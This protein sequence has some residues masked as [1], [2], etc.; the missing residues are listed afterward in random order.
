VQIQ[1]AG[2]DEALRT[3]RTGRDGLSPEEADRRLKE[4]GPNEVEQIVGA[5]LLRRFGAEFV[6]LFALI[7]WSAAA[8]AFTA[9]AL[10]PGQGMRRLGWAIVGVIVVNAVASFWQV[11]RAERTIESLRR[12]LPARDGRTRGLRCR[13]V[14]PGAGARRRGGARE[15]RSGAGRLSGARRHRRTNRSLH[16]DRRI[17]PARHRSIPVG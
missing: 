15:R 14:E 6:H 12:L 11:Y 2:V 5:S 9:D 8:L 1:R 13:V 3:L 10:Q 17:V 7:L 16:A 4:F